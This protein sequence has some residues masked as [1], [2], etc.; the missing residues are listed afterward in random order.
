[1]KQLSFF[2]SPSVTDNELSHKKSDCWKLF[3]D[4]AARNN[5]GP[6]AAGIYLLKNEQLYTQKG[7]YLG[8]KTNNQAEYLA[9]IIGLLL[10]RHHMQ[11]QDVLLIV[12]DSQL[13]VRQFHGAYKV[14]EPHLKALHVVAQSLVVSL[15]YS[16]MHIFREDNVEA[17]A[18]A[19][20]ALDHKIALPQ[21]IKELLQRYEITL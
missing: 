2:E 21:D 13:L 20:Y 16:I 19:N 14:K 6:A 10:V 8:L 7:F 15:N 17:D 1:M 5:P 18:Q 4:G 3:V 11:P 9:L 12:S